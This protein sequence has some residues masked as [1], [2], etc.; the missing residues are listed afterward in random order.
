MSKN[1]KVLFQDSIEEEVEVNLNKWNQFGRMQ[2]GELK[3]LAYILDGTV[4][5]Y[6]KSLEEIN[7]IVSGSA[8]K[9]DIVEQVK[10]IIDLAIRR[11]ESLRNT[12]FNDELPQG[13]E[14]RERLEHENTKK[15]LEEMRRNIADITSEAERNYSMTYDNYRLAFDNTIMGMSKGKSDPKNDTVRYENLPSYNEA[16]KQTVQMSVLN[17]VTGN[18][19]NTPDMKTVPKEIDTKRHSTGKPYDNKEATAP[20]AT[21]HIYPQTPIAPEFLRTNNFNWTAPRVNYEPSPR[22]LEPNITKFK[23][24]HNEDVE[25]WIFAINQAFIRSQIPLNQRLSHALPFVENLPFTI[26]K[27]FIQANRTWGEFETELRRM[28]VRHDSAD[29]YRSELMQLTHRNGMTIDAYNQQ[30]MKCTFYLRTMDD[31]DKFYYYVN[32][33]KD[34]NIQIQAVH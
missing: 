9:K 30:F 33:L 23:G 16:N 3:Q 34:R 11:K 31:G 26:L 27:A 14:E 15:L 19:I 6:A 13:L 20:C 22:K 8:N 10:E 5:V 21:E 1:R 29:K 18:E 2:L 17:T 12:Y 7:K 32:G 25:D 4:T 28:Y 24:N